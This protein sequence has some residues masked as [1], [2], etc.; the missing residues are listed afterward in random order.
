MVSEIALY[1]IPKL[2][3]RDKYG[4]M[5]GK[6]GILI[7][8]S[9]R[10]GEGKYEKEF[11]S[12]F[13]EVLSDMQ[14]STDY[15]LCDGILGVAISYLYLSG[16]N[17]IKGNIDFLLKELDMKLFKDFNPK[18]I[19]KEEHELKDAIETLLY[20]SIR[21]RYKFKN[22]SE[23]NIYTNLAIEL[24]EKTYRTICNVGNS[25]F[26]DEPMPFSLLSYNMLFLI[27]MT[28]LAHVDFYK[29]RVKHLLEELCITM[30]THLPYLEANRLLKL[31]VLYYVN[32]VIELNNRYLEH[33]EILQKNTSLDFIFDKELNGREFLFLDGICGIYLLAI[34]INKFSSRKIYNISKADILNRIDRSPYWE[35]RNYTVNGMPIG[36]NGIYGLKMFIEYV[37]DEK[38]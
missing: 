38:I 15:S 8:L 14:N 18:G 33:I 35:R 13:N 24:F 36:L 4:L 11:A 16:Q 1:E 26:H 32:S 31:A 25:F 34:L 12:I 20:L 19:F 22:G 9:K 5:S 28:N 3:P 30:T 7:Y 6:C 2:L 29:I 37:E 27:C 10:I 17:G 21:I 23:K